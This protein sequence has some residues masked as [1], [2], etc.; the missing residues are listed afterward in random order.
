MKCYS[1]HNDKK[2]TRKQIEEDGYKK[3]KIVEEAHQKP[4]LLFEQQ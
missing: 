3:V 4:G 2:D 1:Q